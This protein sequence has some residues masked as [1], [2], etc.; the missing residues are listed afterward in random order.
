MKIETSKINHEV[1][2]TGGSSAAKFYRGQVV[3]T[4]EQAAVQVSS[5]SQTSGEIQAS[6]SRDNPRLRT[7]RG[8]EDG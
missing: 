5:S 2:V 8:K 3:T 1:R 6:M 4:S 7:N